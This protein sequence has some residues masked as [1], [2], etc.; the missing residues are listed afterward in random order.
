[1]KGIGMSETSLFGLEGKKAIGIG[2]G[3]GRGRGRRGIPVICEVRGDA[4]VATVIAA[5]EAQLDGIDVMV[6][7]VGAAAFGPLLDTT[8]AV[9]DQQIHLNLR[10]FFLG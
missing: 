6:S 4:Q 2:G 5:A 3:Q 1:M 7:I 8:A 10:Y 9:F